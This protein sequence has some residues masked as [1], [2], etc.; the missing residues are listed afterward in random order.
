MALCD[1]GRRRGAAAEEALEDNDLA[2]L[3]DV[4]VVPAVILDSHE[5]EL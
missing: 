1:A 2:E 3:V 5:A 4:G